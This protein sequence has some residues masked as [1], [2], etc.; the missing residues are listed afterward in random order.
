[1]L[2]ILNELV[3][4]ESKDPGL[5]GVSL[6]DIELSRDLS[7]AKVYFSL[8]NPDDV[9]EAALEGLQR[10]AG[11]LRGKLGSAIKIRHVP[12]LRFFHD[13]SVEHSIKIS[14]LIESAN[15]TNDTDG[16]R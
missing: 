11:F 16:S 9:P 3:R 10:A 2:R 15:S 6:T 1:M 14:Q 5:G 7:V 13:D 12:E 4:F 8:L